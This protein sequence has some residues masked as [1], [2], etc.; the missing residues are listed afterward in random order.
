M[1][2]MD[3]RI[4]KQRLEV[5]GPAGEIDSMFSSME[6]IFPT[7]KQLLQYQNEDE[8]KPGGKDEE[9]GVGDTQQR[10][11]DPSTRTTKRDEDDEVQEMTPKKKR[12][13]TKS[14]PPLPAAAENP[15][16]AALHI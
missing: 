9:A 10:P 11:S 8:V 3:W 6:D 14:N 2:V 12:N 4:M 7:G 1:A 13:R 5:P 16:D 15:E